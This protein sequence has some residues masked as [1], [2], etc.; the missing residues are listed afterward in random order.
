MTEEFSDVLQR[1]VEIE[2][3]HT[4]EFELGEFSLVRVMNHWEIQFEDSEGIQSIIVQL[5]DFDE[6]D[7]FHFTKDAEDLYLTKSTYLKI[8]HFC[9]DRNL[10]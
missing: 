3:V 2:E 5:E 4:F 8:E 6:H 1:D 7:E 10:L 9:Q